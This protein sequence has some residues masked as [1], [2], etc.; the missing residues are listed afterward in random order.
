MR[1][2]LDLFKRKQTPITPVEVETL[3]PS[4]QH[5]RTF[6]CACMAT[7]RIRSRDARADGPSNFKAFPPAHPRKG[8]SQVPAEYLNWA[9]LAAER[10]WETTPDV[11]C[12]AC[13]RGM[14]RSQYKTARRKGKL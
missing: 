2:L 4:L 14:T 9:G 11:K 3:K 5:V 7:M 1:R 12:P 6:V 13:Q 8:H 10:G